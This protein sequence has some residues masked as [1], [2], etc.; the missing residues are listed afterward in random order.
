MIALLT[1][2]AGAQDALGNG[3]AL[4]ANPGQFGP[5]NFARPSLVDELRFRNAIATGNAPGGLSFRGDLG[6]RAAGEF[7]GSLGSDSLFAFRRDSLYSGLAG[8][9][10]RG[11]DA[12]QYQFALTTG[13]A[14]PRNLMGNLSYARDDAYSTVAGLP[15][16][17]QSQQS[18][19]IGMNQDQLDLEATGRALSPQPLVGGYDSGS[20]MGTLR[21]PSTYNASSTMQP[22]LLSVYN[23]GIDQRPVGLIASPLLGITPT[24]LVDER[25][26][27]NPLV[28]RPSNADLDP[29][30][31]G[32]LPST[33]VV[34]SYDGLIQQMRER[35]EKVR[36]EQPKGDQSVQMQPGESNDDWLVRQM[37]DLRSKLYG[38]A[39]A[40]QTTD[41]ANPADPVSTDPMDPMNPTD[42]TTQPGASQ[43]GTNGTDANAEQSEGVPSERTP[44]ISIPDNSDSPL[45]KRIEESNKRLD[46][47]NQEFELYDPTKIAVDPETLE[48]L[49]GSASEEIKQLLD[50]NAE[51]R[52]LYSE[53]IIAG[54]RLIAD[55]RFFDAEERFTHALSMKPGD[56][57]AQLGRLHAQIGAGM[58]LS[59]SVNL[60]N[61]FSSNPE[62]ITSRYAEGIMPSAERVKSL[63]E[64]LGERAG[65]IEPTVRTRPIE[66]D[67]V[68]V[69]AGMLLA[70]IGY[71]SGDAKA[72]SQG[73]EVV[74][75]L[76]ANTDRRF[77]SLLEQ[78]WVIPS[79]TDT[80]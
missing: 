40:N 3:Q 58:L 68:R 61:L 27:A 30:V 13:S 18:V 41:P 10:I 55:S 78:L 67:R 53:H 42:A 79:D 66:T 28:G 17:G 20:M 15:G 56:V 11:T 62:L 25:D 64:Q 35:V 29:T 5:G 12:I 39:P 1:A 52:D 44:L 33:R 70:Y 65:V 59:A 24:P 69:S 46:Q 76:G 21:S 60:Q 26:M 72:I 8:M 9:G 22:S 74:S 16:R 36:G 54:Q 77:A 32:G 2:Q 50:P 31:P 71:Q 37:R 63:K 38:E 57:T 4:D 6:Y 73:L 49:R 75:T 34:T 43:Q 45:S 47:I 14:P 48:V 23:Q 7:T 51:S 80:P 19:T